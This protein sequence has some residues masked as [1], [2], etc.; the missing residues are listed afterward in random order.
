MRP[1]L[2]ED[3]LPEVHVDRDEDPILCDG[4]VEYRGVTG[5]SAAI[6]DLGH[7]MPLLASPLRDAMAGRTVDQESHFPMRTASSE[8]FAMTA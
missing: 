6:T 1:P 7:V 5:I 4:P 2:T 8:S 3:E